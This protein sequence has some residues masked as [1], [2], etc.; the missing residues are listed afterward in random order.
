VGSCGSAGANAQQGQM[1]VPGT[2]G[3]SSMLAA[4]AAAVGPAAGGAAAGAP[5]PAS[6]VPLPVVQEALAVVL[7]DLGTRAKNA[8]ACVCGW[9]FARE[10]RGAAQVSCMPPQHCV[11]FLAGARSSSKRSWLHN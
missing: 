11:P 10:G 6:A 7:T 1:A 5:Q 2:L 3:C 9:V 4:P 8:G